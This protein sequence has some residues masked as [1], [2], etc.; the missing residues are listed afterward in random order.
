MFAKL[1]MLTAIGLAGLAQ[2]PSLG[3]EVGLIKPA[4]AKQGGPVG[5][6]CH[7]INSR[8]DGP[9]G[10]MSKAKGA[11]IP[12]GRCVFTRVNLRAL[13]ALAYLNRF[14]DDS[15]ILGGPNWL[16]S[17]TFDI[18]G[19]AEQPESASE[20]QLL[21]M[22]KTLLE[23]RF[24]LQLHRETRA[25]DGFALVV[26]RNG[27]KLQRSAGNEPN[28]GLMRIAGQPLAGRNATMDA[29]T[30][31]LAGVLGRPIVNRTGLDGGYNFTLTWT[32]GEGESGGFL[33]NLPAEVR[34]RLPKGD[35]NGP[36]I[37]TALQE[38]LGLRLESAKVPA[39]VLVIDR[40]ERPS[41][42]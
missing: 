27:P 32:P 23:D 21:A 41:L 11:G 38:Q 19:K 34:D 14:T 7:G 26:A 18:E 4:D 24:K 6:T 42:N 1:S 12:L 5:G 39:D 2:S 10:Q 17:E 20:A 30:R 25:A 8:S 36:S 31:T 37:F 33:A 22:V 40:V 28:G 3:F 15:R 29:L 9:L 35:P 16:A 13:I